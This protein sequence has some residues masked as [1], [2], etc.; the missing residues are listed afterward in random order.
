MIGNGV[1]IDLASDLY[2]LCT[3][4]W[5]ARIKDDMYEFNFNWQI[6]MHKVNFYE[7]YN[8]S[9]SKNL[10]LNAMLMDQNEEVQPTVVSMEFG[11]NNTGYGPLIKDRLIYVRHDVKCEYTH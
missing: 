6:Q 2:L 8:V 1:N 4:E 10:G 3:D 9:K 11:I 5:H 7:Y